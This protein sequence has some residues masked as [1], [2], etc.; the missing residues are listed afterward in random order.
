MK[1]LFAGNGSK[2]IETV[3][4]FFVIDY[5]GFRRRSH[6]HTGFT[7]LDETQPLAVIG[8]AVTRKKK[9]TA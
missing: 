9:K 5:I 1:R 6:C 7:P 4:S 3:F 2:Y 8:R